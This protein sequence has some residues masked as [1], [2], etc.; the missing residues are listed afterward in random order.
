VHGRDTTGKKESENRPEKG[1]KISQAPGS[2]IHQ[3]QLGME[4]I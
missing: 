2:R 3:G 4:E 1:H